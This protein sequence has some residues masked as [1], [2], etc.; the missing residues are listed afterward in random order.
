MGGGVESPAAEVDVI[1]LVKVDVKLGKGTEALRTGWTLSLPQKE[2]R[3]RMLTS[4]DC[5]K[6]EAVREGLRERN[7][8]KRDLPRRP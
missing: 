5:R 8:E 3:P 1:G 7:G 2:R 6:R 4:V